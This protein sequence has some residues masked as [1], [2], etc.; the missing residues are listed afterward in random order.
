[1]RLD[2]FLVQE[3]YFSSRTKAREAIDKGR[4]KV[5]GKL[6]KASFSIIGTEK[7][8]VIYE[9]LHFVSRGGYKLWHALT[10]FEMDVS[11]FRALDVGAST[12]GFTDCLLQKGAKEVIALD[13]GEGQLNENL[14]SDQR[15]K[16]LE[17]TNI[18]DLD[19]LNIGKFDIITIDVSFISLGKFFYRLPL[20]LQDTGEIVAL[21]KPQF[22]AG[23]SKVGK[24]GIVKD[25]SV[26]IEVLEN[27]IKVAKDSGFFTNQLTYSPI[28]GGSGNLEFLGRFSRKTSKTPTT[29]ELKNLLKEARLQVMPS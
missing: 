12:G 20:F 7:I 15:V 26:H 13:V 6:A 28:Y 22:E 3:G 11:G 21:I 14:R 16:S 25:P 27:V 17:K 10:I 19:P 29:D 8:D 5:D 24:R 2:L 9:D 4:V 18:R 1:M 23:P